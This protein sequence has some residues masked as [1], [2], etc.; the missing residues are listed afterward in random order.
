[1]STLQKIPPLVAALKNDATNIFGYVDEN[2]MMNSRAR[3]IYQQ[4]PG[5]VM[6][7]WDD[8]T[9]TEG[10]MEAWLHT[11]MMFVRADK[12]ASPLDIGDLIVNGIPVPGDGLRWRYCPV[13]DGV[14][15][16]TLKELGWTQ[17]TE[18]ID[19]LYIRTEIKESGDA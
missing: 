11:L 13:M 17:D 10:E 5:T 12:G 14:L 7:Y 2:P 8:T 9:I 15:P 19:Y 3:A 1:M 18:G 6:V 4:A 16:A